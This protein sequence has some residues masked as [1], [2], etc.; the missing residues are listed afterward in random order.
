MSDQE[1][2]LGLQS[3]LL[4]MA[5]QIRAAQVVLPPEDRWEWDRCLMEALHGMRVY[6]AGREQIL[7]LMKQADMVEQTK[8]DRIILPV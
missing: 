7:A 1:I 4:L 8:S 2:D 5:S 6:L 3:L